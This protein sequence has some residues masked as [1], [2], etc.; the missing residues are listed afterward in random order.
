MLGLWNLGP[1]GRDRGEEAGSSNLDNDGA[2]LGG[3]IG[4][5]WQYHRWVFG[6]EADGG[7]LWA[8]DS[9]NINIPRTDFDPFRVSSS[10][11]THYLFT[12]APRIGYAVG[13]WLP[14]VTGGLAVGDLDYAQEITFPTGIVSGQGAFREGG[15]ETETNCGWMVGGGLQYA[16]TNHWSVRGQ[17]QYVDLGDISFESNFISNDAPAH[18]HAEVTEHNA[19]FAVMYKF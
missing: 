15:S 2:E 1:I 7:Y 5:N 8:R 4:F 13:R 10:F 11:K 16:L 6:L 14:Y 9:S 18:H 3:L 17:Y 12:V 19:S